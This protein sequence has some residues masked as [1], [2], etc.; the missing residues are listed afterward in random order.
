MTYLRAFTRDALT[1]FDTVSVSSATTSYSGSIDLGTTSGRAF[2][3]VLD[4]SVLDVSDGDEVYTLAIQLGDADDFSGA[5]VERAAIR[6]G[7]SSQ[8]AL[9]SAD[10]GPGRF[11]VGV[12]NVS[13]GS[14]FRFARLAVTA[15]GT[16]PSVTVSAFLAVDNGFGGGA[17]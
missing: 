8:L 10:S 7:D 14:G 17:S 4:V 15:A 16:S 6:L 1:T 3:A 12:D 13:G 5:T 2:H 9:N 11:V